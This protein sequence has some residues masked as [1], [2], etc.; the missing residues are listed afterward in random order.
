MSVDCSR[1]SFHPWKDFFGVVMQQARAAS[2]F[3]RAVINR[4]EG[5]EM[6]LVGFNLQGA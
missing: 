4:I 2:T 3:I 1:F 5:G 6:L